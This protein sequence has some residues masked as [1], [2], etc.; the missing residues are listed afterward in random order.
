M[1]LCDVVNMPGTD[2]TYR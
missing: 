2:L 1:G